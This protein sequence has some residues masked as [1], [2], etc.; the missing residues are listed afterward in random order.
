MHLRNYGKEKIK[1][2]FGFVQPQLQMNVV[3]HTEAG[4]EAQRSV[5]VLGNNWVLCFYGKETAFAVKRNHLLGMLASGCSFG[6]GV[7]RQTSTIKIWN[8]RE[9]PGLKIEI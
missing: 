9:R 6:L 2:A 7:V 4:A 3:D 1:D 5:R 8:E